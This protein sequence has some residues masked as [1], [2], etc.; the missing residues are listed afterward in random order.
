MYR[1]KNGDIKNLNGGCLL[2]N[3]SVHTSPQCNCLFLTE[4]TL[5]T[6]P[7]CMNMTRFPNNA[8]QFFPLIDAF[9]MD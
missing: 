6:E 5:I 3:N 2:T 9:I 1:Q 4:L 8:A 7:A